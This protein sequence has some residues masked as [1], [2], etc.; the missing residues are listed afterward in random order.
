VPRVS[1]PEH[2]VRTR[3]C[4]HPEGVGVGLHP[5]VDVEVG[6][7]T[8]SQVIDR[9]KG[10]VRV[11]VDPT[12]AESGDSKEATQEQDQD[13]SDQRLAAFATA[14]PRIGVRAS[15]RAR[16]QGSR[17][18]HGAVPK[19]QGEEHLESPETWR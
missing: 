9:S 17:A 18:Y 19:F 3:H 1:L 6:A 14:R 16:E 8:M 15:C 11:L 7:E 13:G 10:D 12:V 4:Q 5:F 2:Q